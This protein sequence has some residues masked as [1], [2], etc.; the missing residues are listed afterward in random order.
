MDIA[1]FLQ[2]VVNQGAWS[3]EYWVFS[4]HAER[5][6]AGQED[7]SVPIAAA[8]AALGIY[9]CVVHP[10]IAGLGSRRINFCTV[11]LCG[12]QLAQ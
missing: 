3:N 7:K 4:T 9:S 11:Y 8:N 1:K 10:H 12:R 6:Q 2:Y 5:T